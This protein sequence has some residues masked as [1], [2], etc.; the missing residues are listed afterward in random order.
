MFS[1]DS[2]QLPT[3][4]NQDT[5]SS[6]ESS[7]EPSK[8]RS[9]IFSPD[10][11][12]LDNEGSSNRQ[13]LSTSQ[14]IN[15]AKEI[16][17]KANSGHSVTSESDKSDNDVLSS[18]SGSSAD[19]DMLESRVSQLES[20]LITNHPKPESKDDQS[21][22]GSSDSTTTSKAS[23]DSQNSD[24]RSRSESQSKVEHTSDQKL[25]DDD[26]SSHP[27]VN[28]SENDHQSTPQLSQSNQSSSHSLDTSKP[29]DGDQS[30]SEVDQNIIQGDQNAAQSPQHN[31]TTPDQVINQAS[32]QNDQNVSHSNQ[33]TNQT[34]TQSQNNDQE[35]EYDTNQHEKHSHQS[36]QATNKHEKETNLPDQH[37]QA[38][39]HQSE[40]T[41]QDHNAS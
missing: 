32:N 7:V 12:V 19:V 36:D 10:T 24:Q 35:S 11:K 17:K 37:D 16:L 29:L 8:R 6:K 41:E 14:T 38:K 39:P 9:V 22:S 25:P 1:S 33:D 31:Q 18:S 26:Q 2:K 3:D 34:N 15:D 5:P 4:T 28:T 40:P 21:S 13:S 20:T 27:V 23:V 30:T